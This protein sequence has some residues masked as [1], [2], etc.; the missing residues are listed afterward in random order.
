MC[1][2][3]RGIIVT[4]NRM[5]M[6]QSQFLVRERMTCGECFDH[7]LDQ[8]MMKK[9][10]CITEGQRQKGYKKDVSFLNKPLS[11]WA[12]N[13]ISVWWNVQQC[14]FS[15]HHK[16]WNFLSASVWGQLSSS[17]RLTVN[18][19]CELI[20]SVHLYSMSWVP[21]IML[22]FTFLENYII[23]TNLSMY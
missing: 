13:L 1:N 23:M 21:H 18:V 16:Q 3:R 9:S 4:S 5:E 8:Q 20:R 2:I 17:N 22:I 15:S 19:S 11:R 10:D 14:W 7:W 6:L 12:S